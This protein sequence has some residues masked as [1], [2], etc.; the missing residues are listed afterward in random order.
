[1]GTSTQMMYQYSQPGTCRQ[2]GWWWRS[3]VP[4]KRRRG[5]RSC[6]GV[7]PRPAGAS[8]LWSTH[9]PTRLSCAP[10][11]AASAT[12][13]MGSSSGGGSHSIRQ[14]TRRPLDS[15]FRDGVT[16]VRR[17]CFSGS[18]APPVSPQRNQ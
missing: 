15:G 12:N 1:M 6:L 14:S 5:P 10:S 4:W 13:G 17:A 9:G 18:T 3:V 8:P 7:T 16:S 2:Q 11:D